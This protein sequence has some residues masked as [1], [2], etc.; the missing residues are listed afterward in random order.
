VA[1]LSGGERSR[2]ALARLAADDANLLV[3]DE[4][5]NHLDLWARQALETALHA[6]DGTVLIVSHDRYF[7]DCVADHLVVFEPDGTAIFPGSYSQYVAFRAGK[8]GTRATSSVGDAHSAAEPSRGAARSA[9]ASPNRTKWRFPYRKV[10]EIEGEIQ[11]CEAEVEHIHR[12]LALPQTHRDGAAVK[13]HQ[14][15]LVALG[16]SLR[17]LYEHWEEALER[18]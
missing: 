6:F 12:H 17:Q 9:E 3:L 7:L 8:G 18:H 5:T 15:R 11:A 4:P 13:A 1:S 16:D 2:A 14:A 10:A